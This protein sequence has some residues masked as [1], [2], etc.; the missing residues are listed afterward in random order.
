MPLWLYFKKQKVSLQ[1]NPIQFHRLLLQLSVSSWQRLDIHL[2]RSHPTQSE[3]FGVFN[4]CR[5][6]CLL[7]SKKLTV[8]SPRRW[9]FAWADWLKVSLSQKGADNKWFDY[10]EDEVQKKQIA[11]ELH[12]QMCSVV[13]CYYNNKKYFPRAVFV[14]DGFFLCRQHWNSTRLTTACWHNEEQPITQTED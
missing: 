1:L 13:E 12:R 4:Q 9:R 2:F 10:K 11:F 14:H 3:G 8:Y 6:A 5:W 7:T